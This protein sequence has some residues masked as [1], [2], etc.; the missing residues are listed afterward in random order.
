MFHIRTDDYIL[1]AMSGAL[2]QGF[3][4]LCEF[5]EERKAKCMGFCRHLL[6]TFDH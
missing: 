5:G 6:L 2:L 4:A 3:L 1:V